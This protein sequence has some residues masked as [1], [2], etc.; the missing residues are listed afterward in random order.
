VLK[1]FFQIHDPTTRNRQGTD[2]GTSNRSA[3]FYPS[4]EQRHVAEDTIDDVNASGL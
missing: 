2:V 1:Y 4:E 3:I